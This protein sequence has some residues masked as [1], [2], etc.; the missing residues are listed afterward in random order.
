MGFVDAIFD[1]DNSVL[2]PSDITELISSMEGLEVVSAKSFLLVEEIF[3]VLCWA[4]SLVS[5][6]VETLAKSSVLEASLL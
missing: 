2:F 1:E 4:S 3:S 6:L 5:I